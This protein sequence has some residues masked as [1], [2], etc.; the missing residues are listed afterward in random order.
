M[1]GY[2]VAKPYTINE[3]YGVKQYRITIDSP[4]YNQPIHHWDAECRVTSTRKIEKLRKKAI[5]Y[6]KSRL[7]S[8]NREWREVKL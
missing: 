2:K 8:E 5:E 4:G 1:S 6:K 7:E 3:K